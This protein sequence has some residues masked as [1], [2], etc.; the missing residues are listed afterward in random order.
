MKEKRFYTSIIFI[1]CVMFISDLAYS[2][3]DTLDGPV[4][5]TA[6]K[7]LENGDVTPVLKWVKKENENEIRELF[8]KTMVV[9]SLGP[10]A[11]EVADMY[12]L[13]TLVRIHRAGEGQPYTGLKPAG[14]ADAAIIKADRALQ[15]GSADELVK[16]ISKEIA[17]GVQKRFE[18]AI[19]KKKNADKSIDAGR[20]FVEAYVGFLHYTENIFNT[21]NLEGEG[22]HH[23]AH[24][25]QGAAKVNCTPEK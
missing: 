6:K 15:L 23:E 13:E 16:E 25:D 20:E 10:E 5:M 17:S 21:V 1:I 11:K 7:S 2:H 12:F 14:E 4:V 9:R 24:P 3:C 22:V 8:K 18:L 19:E